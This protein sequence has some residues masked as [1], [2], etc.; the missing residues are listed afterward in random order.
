MTKQQ[1]GKEDSRKLETKLKGLRLRLQ[2]DP[3]LN[4]L[5]EFHDLQQGLREA[6]AIARKYRRLEKAN[7]TWDTKAISFSQVKESDLERLGLHM[8]GQTIDIP[9]DIF[10]RYRRLRVNKQHD[11]ESFGNEFLSSRDCKNMKK[12][13]RT[14]HQ[15]CSD[16]PE[17]AARIVIDQLLIAMVALVPELNIELFL[18]PELRIA[19]AKDQLVVYH[20]SF[21]TLVTGLADYAMMKYDGPSNPNFRASA[22]AVHGLGDL[23]N[24]RIWLNHSG[25]IPVEAKPLKGLPAHLIRSVPQVIT[26]ASAM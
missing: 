18:F 23:M 5:R 22:K 2:K 7:C 6:T 17:A 20:G 10:S 14:L 1:R 11:I 9:P 24:T 4:R 19:S 3:R 26:Q 8:P 12:R 15:F 21:A 25:L 16:S 13:L